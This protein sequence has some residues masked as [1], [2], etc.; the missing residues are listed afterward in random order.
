MNGKKVDVSKVA[1]Y[2]QE[3]ILGEVSTNAAILQ[4]MSRDASVIEMQPEMV[5]Y[6]RVTSDIRK[7]TRF[8]WQL[9]EKGHVLP[10]TARGGGGD[11][12]GAA[13][14]SGII[15]SFPA[16][17][18]RILEFDVKQKLV[19]VQ[20]GMNAKGLNDALALHGVGIPVLPIAA[21]GGTIGGA[22]SNNASGPLSGKYGDMSTWTHQLE[23]VLANGDV[24]Q[25][26]RLSR[27]E[28][29][30]K[31]GLQTFEGEIYRNIDNLI[32]DNKDLIES[33]LLSPIR[34]NVGY[35]SITKV[36]RKDGSFDLTPLIV[37]SQGTLGII[38]E[39]ILKS[40][41]MSMHMGVAA[42]AFSN[43]E[44]ARDALDQLLAL[45]PA[46]AEYYSGELFTIA[47]GRG[48]Q[49]DLLKSIGDTASAVILIGFDDFSERARLK[50]LK[51][52]NK[53][54]DNDDVAVASADGE[55]AIPILA[56]REVTTF[57]NVPDG[58]ELSA[59]PLVDGAY[60]P[61]ER[62]EEFSSS[63]ETL[64]VKYGVTLPIH[65]R[66]LEN[67]L[68]TRPVLQLRKVGDKQK[69][70]KLLDEYSSLVERHG[71]H[72]IAE[73]GE[74]RVKA[75]FAHAHLDDDVLELF[76]VVKAIFDPQGILNPGVKQVLEIRQLVSH[77][78]DN[79][80]TAAFADYVA[81]S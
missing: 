14:G 65:S 59:P 2:L 29:N 16:H 79:Y 40:E 44:A 77:L 34:D 36:K 75:R 31:K 45:D 11:Q 42:L 64:A 46:F 39:M 55:E 78:R 74:G 49:Y 25:T 18:N 69:I 6:P 56:L 67:I 15:L 73:D 41:F 70:F 30:K 33:K 8:A 81:H 61:R 58:K 50:K 43:K 32:E 3:H 62:F 54:F 38:S 10:I 12:T 21:T 71:G 28:L 72:L 68:Y 57:V 52:V 22:V 1:A 63:L 37:G 19:R 47:A 23:V 60:V 66:V 7:I 53:L 51:K 48:K 17:M 27:R 24:L 76:K 4:A 13:I 35:S 20:P 26:E 5:V 9:A 80:D